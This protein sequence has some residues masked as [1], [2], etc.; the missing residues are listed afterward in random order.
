VPNPMAWS[1]IV[2]LVVAGVFMLRAG[3]SA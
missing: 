2:L 1:G 3:R